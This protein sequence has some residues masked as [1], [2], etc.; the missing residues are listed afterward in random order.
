MPLPKTTALARVRSPRPHASLLLPGRHTHLTGFTRAVLAPL[1]VSSKPGKAARTLGAS[2][3]LISLSWLLCFP[4]QTPFKRA[5]S[6]L[7]PSIHLQHLPT[8]LQPKH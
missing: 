8:W 6:T 4:S 3:S 7:A 1:T 2:S 5:N